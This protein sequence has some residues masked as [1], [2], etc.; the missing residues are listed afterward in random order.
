M[1]GERNINSCNQSLSVLLTLLYK[2]RIKIFHQLFSP[3]SRKLHWDFY[4]EDK[5]KVIHNWE[6]EGKCNFKSCAAS[7]YFDKC[8]PEQLNALISNLRPTVCNLTSV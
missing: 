6:M 4:V 3:F 2:K 8:N 7:L 5:H 1:C